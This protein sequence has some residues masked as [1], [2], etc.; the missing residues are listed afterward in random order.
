[1]S[2]FVELEE[3]EKRLEWALSDQE[4][5]V[6]QA[7]LDDLSV[8]AADYG[9]AS[10]SALTAPANVKR[11]ILA[12][13]TRY[14]KNLEGVIQSRA[15]DETLIWPEVE[16]MG[17]ATFTADEVRRITETAMGGPVQFGTIP[18]EQYGTCYVDKSIQ[19][20]DSIDGSRP[21]PWYQE[22]SW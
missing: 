2:A 18:V 20:V 4:K 12:A 8:D 17:S 16:G 19:Y 5:L 7:A 21:F 9:V 13:A 1:M 10:W 3:L 15:G 11:I 22:K 14:M 6:A